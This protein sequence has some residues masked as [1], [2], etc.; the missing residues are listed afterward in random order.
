MGSRTVNII[1][2]IYPVIIYFLITYFISLIVK[3]LHIQIRSDHQFIITLIDQIASLII[4]FFIYKSQSKQME[5]VNYY[6]LSDY[7]L[8][9]TLLLLLNTYFIL[10]LSGL[11]I[12]TFNL[13]EIFSGYSAVSDLIKKEPIGMQILIIGLLA[14]I[15]EELL[16]RG[17]NQFGNDCSK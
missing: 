5:K 11:I 16:F 13:N 6:R 15:V 9:N 14:P 3:I 8:K 10:N 2:I 4:I 7:G 12:V 1:K 17:L